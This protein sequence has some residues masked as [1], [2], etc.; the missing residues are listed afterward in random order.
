M[1]PNQPTY[2]YI[3]TD[4]GGEPRYVGMT[5]RPKKRYSDHLSYQGGNLH[6]ANWIKKL[7]KDG[8]KPGLTLICLV[9]SYNAGLFEKMFIKAISERGHKLVNL[10]PG[11]E[12]SS[13][14]PGWKDSE[15]T[16]KK[17][18]ASLAKARAEG[19]MKISKEGAA[20]ISEY[21][22]NR[23]VTAE[24][25]KKISDANRGKVRT[26]EYKE[27]IRKKLSGRTMPKKHRKKISESITKWHA[28]R[29][30]RLM[31]E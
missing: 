23:I 31:E 7:K 29:K 16:K 24:T 28:D 13:R 15:D 11:G 5:Y 26:S 9:D 1:K 12:G 18:T 6:K 27:N 30:A 25:R 14:E 19:R 8:Y 10:A 17:R 2:I 3:L 4:P 20:S 21:M 22:S